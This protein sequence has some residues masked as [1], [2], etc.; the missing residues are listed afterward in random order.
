MLYDAP[1]PS[2]SVLYSIVVGSVHWPNAEGLRDVQRLVTYKTR[3]IC[4]V[5]AFSLIHICTGADST[6]YVVY[7][8]RTQDRRLSA[9]HAVEFYNA[10]GAR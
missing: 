7:C 9:M 2:G 3:N 6:E 10:H 4:I 5:Y 8:K 1:R